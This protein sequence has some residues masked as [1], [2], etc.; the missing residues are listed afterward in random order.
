MVGSI[1]KYNDTRN[2]FIRCNEKK[3]PEEVKE[4]ILK[5]EHVRTVHIVLK[6]LAM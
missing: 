2:C 3:K 4:T 1:Y 6:I 5:K